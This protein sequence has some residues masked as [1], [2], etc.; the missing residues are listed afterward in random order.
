[1]YHPPPAISHPPP[2]LL[3]I[4]VTLEHNAAPGATLDTGYTGYPF[5]WMNGMGAEP[6]NGCCSAYS[7][8]AQVTQAAA[9]EAMQSI[10]P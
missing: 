7:M 3:A 4:R 9:S 8:K 2:T 5:I 6:G 1:M 10:L